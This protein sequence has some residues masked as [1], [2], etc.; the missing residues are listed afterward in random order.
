MTIY[1]IPVQEWVIGKHDRFAYMDTTLAPEVQDERAYFET[2][3]LPPNACCLLRQE[4]YSHELSKQIQVFLT[5]V[6]LS[7]LLV[8][9]RTYSS[10]NNLHG[11][12]ICILCLD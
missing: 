5:K 2:I 10:T 11:N 7:G 12:K 6:K 4:V 8:N 3:R 1:V 9:Q